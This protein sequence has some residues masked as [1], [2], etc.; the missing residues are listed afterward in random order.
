MVDLVGH[1]LRAQNRLCFYC[2]CR[3]YPRN[4]KDRYNPMRV[5]RDHVFPVAS[6]GKG[7]INNVVLAHRQ[8]NEKKGSRQPTERE[9]E[10]TKELYQKMGLTAFIKLEVWL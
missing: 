5:T 3:M 9:I 1:L 7:L 10:K 2:N 8:C 4:F 6:T